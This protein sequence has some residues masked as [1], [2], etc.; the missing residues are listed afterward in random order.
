MKTGGFYLDKVQVAADTFARGFPKVKLYPAEL[1]TDAGVIGAASIA[2]R[3]L[4]TV[5]GPPLLT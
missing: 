3:L 4:A 2:A 1:G 5:E